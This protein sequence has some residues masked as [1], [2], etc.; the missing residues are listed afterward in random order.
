MLREGVAKLVEL[1]FFLDLTIALDNQLSRLEVQIG[2][3]G[4]FC[5]HLDVPLRVERDVKG[6]GSGLV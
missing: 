2:Q 4:I 5:V 1:V 3:K 6:A